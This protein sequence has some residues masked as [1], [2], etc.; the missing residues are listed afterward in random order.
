MTLV[1]EDGSQL[2]QVSPLPNTYVDE[3]TFRNYAVERGLTDFED[4]SPQTVTTAAIETALKKAANYMKAR[5]RSFWKGSRVRAFQPLDWPRRGVD[6]PDF[7]DP[8]YRQVNVP[9]QFQDTV[10]IG[11][12]VIPEEVKEAQMLLAIEV[13]A[14]GTTATGNLQASL[15][16]LTKREKL[17]DLEV[18][19]MGPSEGGS[20]RQTTVYWEADQ[21]L[22][23]FLR[24]SRPQTAQLVRA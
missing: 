6:I 24:P 20:S 19:Y 5:Y 13:F 16:R 7:F 8:F 12:A 11:T 15:G 1:V 3:T 14:G 17:G 4:D 10:F 22:H 23:P 2:D 21:L 9:L 18:E